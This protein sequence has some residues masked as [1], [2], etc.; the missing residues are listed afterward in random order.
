MW[1]LYLLTSYASHTPTNLY[2]WSLQKGFTAIFVPPTATSQ[3]QAAPCI[4][5]AVGH[6][7]I[8]FPLRLESMGPA[9]CLRTDGWPVCIYLSRT[10]AALAGAHRLS[11][12]LYQGLTYRAV[13]LLEWGSH[14]PRLAIPPPGCH[15][16]THGLWPACLTGLMP[17]HTPWDR[18]INKLV[19]IHR[20]HPWVLAC[21][22]SLHL[23]CQ[24]VLTTDEAWMFLF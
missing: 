2:A 10:D 20:L 18:C 15:S 16:A 5:A 17:A 6:S 12:L 22:K 13:I 4:P 9:L 8:V 7:D 3:E 21:C 23:L 11:W 19:S 1:H 24:V 14:A